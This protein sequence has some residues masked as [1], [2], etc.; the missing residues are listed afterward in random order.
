[1]ALAAA[2]IYAKLLAY[3][4]EYEIAR[5]LTQPELHNEIRRTFDGGRI[6]FNMAPPI[7]SRGH[8]NGRPKKGEIGV[9]ILPVLRVL[10]RMRRVRGTWLDPF[11]HTVERRMERT[12]IAEYEA[13]VDRVLLALT[14]ANHGRAL[15]LLALADEVRGFGSVKGT[16]VKNYY[17]RLARAE[18]QYVAC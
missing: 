2:R 9:W 18:E 13:L 3:K 7:L 12:L 10:A 14:S 16:A 4:D 11:G 6:A 5:L 8:V 15:A 17:S 1:L